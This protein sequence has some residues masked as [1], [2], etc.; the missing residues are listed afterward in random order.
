MTM[1]ACIALPLITASLC[2]TLALAQ[3]T[4]K[5]MTSS[6]DPRL[7]APGQSITIRGCDYEDSCTADYAGDGSW[8]IT[9]SIP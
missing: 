2:I 7:T 5:G 4:I 8:T 6:E 9:R 3:G 1:R